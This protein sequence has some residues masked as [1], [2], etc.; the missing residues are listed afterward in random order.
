METYE[1]TEDCIKCRGRC[2]KQLPGSC[3]PNDISR[4][5]PANSLQESVKLALNSKKYSI[6]WFENDTPLYYIRPATLGK[7]KKF[8]PSWGGICILLTDNGCSLPFDLRPN[9][10]KCIKP[11]KDFRC[12]S[13]IDGNTKFFHGIKWKETGINFDVF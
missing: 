11:N 10:C 2:C 4:L 3:L 9:D 6:G 8:D 7:Y 1:P 12:S 13:S 5:F